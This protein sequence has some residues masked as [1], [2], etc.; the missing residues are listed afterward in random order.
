M[1]QARSKR[2]VFSLLT[3]ALVLASASKINAEVI[4]FA[5]GR[6]MSVK[7]ARIVGDPTRVTLRQG[8]EA[9]FTR[10]IV[11]TT[12]PN[13]G[14]DLPP[15]VALTSTASAVTLVTRKPI[16]SRPFA[17]LIESVALKH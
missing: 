10:P 1:K 8:G 3:S 2:L 4:F 6:T 17:E 11:A 12:P 15:P 7:T 9:P 16:E 5:N 14:P 13:E